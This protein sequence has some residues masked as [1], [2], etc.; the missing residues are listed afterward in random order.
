MILSRSRS[1]PKQFYIPQIAPLIWTSLFIL[2]AALLL[3]T[4]IKI[5]FLKKEVSLATEE[6]KLI[7]R[8]SKNLNWKW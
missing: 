4:T 2:F 7:E 1:L 6:T 5:S 8:V 3:L